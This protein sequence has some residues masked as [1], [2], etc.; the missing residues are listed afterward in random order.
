MHVDFQGFS[1]EKIIKFLDKNK[2]AKCW[3]FSWEEMNPAVPR[4]YQHLS[5]ENILESYHKYP[6]RIVPFYAPD[7]LN[8]KQEMAFENFRAHGIQGCGEL[9]VANRWSD[10]VIEEYLRSISKHH[11]PLVFHMEKPRKIYQSTNTNPFKRLFKHMFNNAFNGVSGY[12]ISKVASKI[13]WLADHIDNNAIHFPGYL[14]DFHEL[15]N[16]IR[17]FP[18]IKFIAHGPHF[19]NNISSDINFKYTYQKGKFSDYGIIDHLLETYDNLY[20]DISGTSGFSAL[21]R[22]TDRT[23]Q[24]LDKHA[25]KILFGTDNTNYNLLRFLQS[26]NIDHKNMEMILYKNAESI[27]E[28]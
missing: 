9:K 1:V 5:I 16:R 8:I 13:P 20:C 2:I 18:E 17:Q 3:L 11:L 27:V 23:K 4:L 14:Y 28:S 12:Y 24:F 21:N 15:E 7:P 26:L 25:R 10:A 22:D 6:D 19:W